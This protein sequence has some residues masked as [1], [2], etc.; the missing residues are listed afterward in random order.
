MSEEVRLPKPASERAN[1]EATLPALAEQTFGKATRRIYDSLGRLERNSIYINTTEHSYALYEYPTNGIQ[2]KV[3]S[4]IVDTNS[5]GADADYEVLRESWT[6]GAERVIGS[7]TEHPDSTGGWS[8]VRTEFDILGR[9]Y[10]TSVPTE[11]S[12]SSPDDPKQ[13]GQSCKIA[14]LPD[15]VHSVL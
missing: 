6:D 15:R 7:R 12:V 8:A 13:W 5:D 2:S 4:T 1:V 10:K 9:V 14:I 3:Y 11:V